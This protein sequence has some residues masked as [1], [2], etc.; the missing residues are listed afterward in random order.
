MNDNPSTI[1]HGLIFDGFLFASYHDRS[2]YIGTETKDRPRWL[3]QN[4]DTWIRLKDISQTAAPPAR[5]ETDV[6]AAEAPSASAPFPDARGERKGEDTDGSAETPMSTSAP[7]EHGVTTLASATAALSP[8]PTKAEL[9]PSAEAATRETN[10]SEIA[11]TPLG[12]TGCKR[13]RSDSRQL[14]KQELPAEVSKARRKLSPKRMRVV[15]EYLRKYPVLSVAA[16][17]AGIHRKTLEYWIKCSEAGHDGYDIKWQGEMWRFHEHC[18][19]AI[20]EAHD[21]QFGALYDYAMGGEVYKK[22]EFLL[23]LGLEGDDAYAKDENGNFIVEAI[24]PP[25]HKMLL[26]LLQL[27]NPERWG[28]KRRK[29]IDALQ[30]GGVLVIGDET[31]KKPENGSAASIK[32]RRWKSYSRRI[33]EEV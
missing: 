31:T 16:S 29:K 10:R 7:S 25:N 12:E 5:C 3:K 20:A 9:P 30:K 11:T 2:S 15:L 4:P 33:G 32:A 6:G 13:G 1:N 17:K 22:D 27:T 26:L 19:S 8:G 24:R 14:K 21:K 18:E 23:S 28:K